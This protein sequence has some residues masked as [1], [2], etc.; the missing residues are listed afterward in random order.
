[1]LAVCDMKI[2]HKSM[3][4]KSN[5]CTEIDKCITEPK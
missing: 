3:C 4:D 5:I 1:M 2:Y